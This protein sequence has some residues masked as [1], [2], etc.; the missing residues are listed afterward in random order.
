MNGALSGTRFCGIEL[1]M[2]MLEQARTRL[3]RSVRLTVGSAEDLPFPSSSFDLI[4][5][6]SVFHFWLDPLACLKEVRRV[7]KDNGGIFITDWCD[8]FLA[9]RFCDWYLRWFNRAHVKTY[10][11]RECKHLLE[12]TGF[13]AI[14]GERYKISWL[15]GLMTVHGIKQERC[16]NS[17]DADYDSAPQ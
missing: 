8:D 2:G 7:L 17:T 14:E 1:S 5:S 6:A 3:S 10:T 9:C 4:V 16:W 15:W 11:L 13:A 12:R